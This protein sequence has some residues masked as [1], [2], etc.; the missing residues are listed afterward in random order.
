MPYKEKPLIVAASQMGPLPAFLF[1]NPVFAGFFAMLMCPVFG[2]VFALFQASIGTV[3]ALILFEASRLGAIVG[4]VIGAFVFIIIAV[5]AFSHRDEMKYRLLFVFGGVLG[6]VFLVIL[7]RFT[8]EYLRDWF[9][10]AGP[11]V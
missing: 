10:T 3:N 7:D 1:S 9:A 2:A 8:L 4:A 5:S 11:L 6:I